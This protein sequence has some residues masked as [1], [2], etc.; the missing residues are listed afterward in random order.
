MNK[1]VWKEKQK[2]CKERDFRFTTV[3]DLPVK[4]LYLPDDIRD[5]DYDKKLSYPGEFPFTRGVYT[6]M[7]RGKLWTMRQFS[8]FGTAKDTN[9]RYKYL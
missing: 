6:N 8:G 9:E 5:F 1:K 4:P 3:S 7:Y 2:T